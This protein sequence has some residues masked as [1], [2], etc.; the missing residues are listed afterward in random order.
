MNVKSTLGIHINQKKLFCFNIIFFF[1]HILLS[2][3]QKATKSM[4]NKA[5]ALMIKL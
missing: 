5:A 4:A 2:V 3:P 1:S